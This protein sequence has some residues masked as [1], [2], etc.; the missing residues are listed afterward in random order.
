MPPVGCL[1]EWFQSQNPLH[2]ILG[3]NTHDDFHHRQYGSTF[4]L[5]NDKITTSILVMGTDPAGLGC[6]V[7]F[8]LSSQTG[9][10]MCIISAYQPSDSALAPTNSISSQ[11]CSYLLSQGDSCPPQT[12]FFHDFGV[13]ISAWQAVGNQIILMADMNG[14]IHKTKITN[15]CSNLGLKNLSCLPTPHYSP[16]YFQTR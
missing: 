11:Y 6:W 14:D 1:Y 3:H 8:T 12:A 16:H 13:A 9:T 4:L 10:T 7:W 5:G 15:F 2:A